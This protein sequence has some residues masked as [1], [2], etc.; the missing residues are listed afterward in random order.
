MTIRER[1]IHAA[2]GMARLSECKKKHGAVVTK[3]NRIIGS[4][5]NIGKSHPDWY[6]EQRYTYHAEIVA[7]KRG[8]GQIVGSNVYSFRDEIWKV[9]RPCRGCISR[10]QRLGVRSMVYIA[11]TTGPNGPIELVEEKI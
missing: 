11:K 5:T 2:I 6:Q 4:G 1:F 10:M 8:N 7:L 3:G 9:S